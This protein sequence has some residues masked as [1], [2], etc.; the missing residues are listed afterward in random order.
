MLI[1]S[2]LSRLLV[3]IVSWAQNITVFNCHNKNITSIKREIKKKKDKVK[4]K[5]EFMLNLEEAY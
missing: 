5:L 1:V 4:I 2:S 3:S